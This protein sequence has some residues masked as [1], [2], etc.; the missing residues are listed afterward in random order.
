MLNG[1]GTDALG[2]TAIDGGPRP[3]T[4]EPSFGGYSVNDVDG[5][6]LDIDDWDVGEVFSLNWFLA[7]IYYHS[8]GYDPETNPILPVGTAAE[9]SPFGF[10]VLNLVRIEPTIGSPAGELPGAVFVDN[11]G[12]DQSVYSFYD[13]VYEIPNPAEFAA[14]VGVG[15]TAP[16]LNPADNIYDAPVNTQLVPEPNAVV[17]LG[18]GIFTAVGFGRRQKRKP[19]SST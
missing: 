2:D 3:Y 7:A 16:F 11:E 10:G 9:G 18:C 14:E 4:P 1:F 13:T 8:A 15:I 17:I 12:F 6:V 5:V 19:D